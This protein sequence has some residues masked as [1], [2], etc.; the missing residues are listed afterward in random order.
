MPPCPCDDVSRTPPIELAVDPRRSGYAPDRL[1]DSWAGKAKRPLSEPVIEDGD[2]RLSVDMRGVV[3]EDIVL[4]TGDV[5]GR[6]GA[7]LEI[8]RPCQALPSMSKYHC[9]LTIIRLIRRNERK[10]SLVVDS[11][12][13]AT[14]VVSFLQAMLS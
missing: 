1:A 12:V 9:L 3:E 8:K 14:D 5:S 13:I 11:R 6:C 2:T 4:Q 10:S 7:L